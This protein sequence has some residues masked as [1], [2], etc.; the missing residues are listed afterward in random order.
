MSFKRTVFGFTPL[1]ILTLKSALR[2]QEMAFYSWQ[3]KTS[4]TMQV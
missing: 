3:G 1:D 4:T 2:S